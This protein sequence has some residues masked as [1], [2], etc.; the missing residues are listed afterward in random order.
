MANY[1]AEKFSEGIK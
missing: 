1:F